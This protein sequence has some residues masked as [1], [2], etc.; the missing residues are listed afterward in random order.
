[1]R[2]RASIWVAACSALLASCAGGP[3][4]VPTSEQLVER[5]R[6]VSAAMLRDPAPGDWLQWGRTYEGQ[7]FSPLTRI[8]RDTVKDLAP[9]WR[10][11]A[12]PRPP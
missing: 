8:N 3:E 2:A 6:P 10:T 7:N 5:M 4:V 11:P 9:V 12:R 1:M